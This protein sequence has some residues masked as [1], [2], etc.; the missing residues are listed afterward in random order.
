M[1]ARPAPTAAPW[2]PAL[3]LRRAS[4]EVRIAQIDRP[5]S[6]AENLVDLTRLELRPNPL[7]C[8]FTT[9]RCIVRT[10]RGVL[11]GGDDRR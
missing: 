3:K 11:A 2:R 9:G 1:Q 4:T 7:A 10:T 6:L 8:G 5:V